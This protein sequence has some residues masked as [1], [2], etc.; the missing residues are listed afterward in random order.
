MDRNILK[1]LHKDLMNLIIKYVEMNNLII[2]DVIINHDNT[3]IVYHLKDKNGNYLESEEMI[4][5]NQTWNTKE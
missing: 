5:S 4:F 1:E 3:K 2:G